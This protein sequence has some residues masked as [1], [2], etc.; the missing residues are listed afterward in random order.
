MNEKEKLRIEMWPLNRIHPFEKNAKEHPE[1]QVEQIARSIEQFGNNDPIAVDENGVIIEGHGRFMALKRLGIDEAPVI[2]LRGLTKDQADQYRIVHN[3]LTMNSG[4]NVE[5]LLEEVKRIQTNWGDFGIDLQKIQEEADRLADDLS[6]VTQDEVPEAPENPV[7]KPGDLL[8]MGESAVV[9]GDSTAPQ[10]WARMRE[11]TGGEKFDLV[12]TDPPYNVNIHTTAGTIHNDNLAE[13]DFQRLLCGAFSHAAAACVDTSPIY[14]WTAS[15][16]R[17]SFLAALEATGWDIRQEI[18]W[19]KSQLVLGRADYQWR[20]EPCLYGWRKG[21]GRDHYFTLDRSQT[22][23]LEETGE[24][25]HLKLKDLRAWVQSMIDEGGT[26]LHEDK[27]SSARING[28]PDS[29]P[30]RLFARQIVNSCKRGGGGLRP[31]HGQRYDRYRRTPDGTASNWSGAR[32]WLLR[33]YRGALGSSHRWEMRESAR[34]GT[35]PQKGVS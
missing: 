14:C 33:R 4:W 23:V 21:H 7:T 32:P 31:L 17:S 16:T 24:W 13:D 35:H 28:H 8:V 5:D 3:Q 19:V 9:C 6:Q 11:F 10:T 18:I 2:V 25:R 15:I 34:G 22:T 27:P 29:K 20:H 26:V 1:E 30:V 12:L